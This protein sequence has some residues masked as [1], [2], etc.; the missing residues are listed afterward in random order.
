MTWDELRT[1]DIVLTTYGTLAAENKRLIKYKEANRAAGQMDEAPMRKLFPLLGPRSL[2]YRVILDES[3]YIKNRGTQAAKA[4]CEL[5]SIT[6][7]CLTGTPMM[8]NVG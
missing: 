1:F 4:A 5:K 6:R 8:N 7:L 2:W 3:Q